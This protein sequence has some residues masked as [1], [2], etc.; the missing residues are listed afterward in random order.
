MVDFK[1]KVERY[2][3]LLIKW[4]KAINLFSRKLP[5]EELDLHI[6]DC[7]F[8]AESMAEEKDKAVLD[9]GTGNGMPGIVLSIYGFK[10][11]FVERNKKKGAFLREAIREL[12]LDALVVD[13]DITNVYDE[14]E[15]MS[16]GVISS[17]AVAKAEDIISLCKPLIKK[18]TVIYLLKNTGTMEEL[19]VAKKRYDFSSQ[20]IENKKLGGK[21]VMKISAV[22]DKDE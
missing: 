21:V 5:I 7:E 15:D 12:G 1:E 22:Q 17:K 10:C 11:I 9:F 6:R 18:D 14:L 20:I 2:K 4:N 3:A 16:P 19:E 13:E 8:L